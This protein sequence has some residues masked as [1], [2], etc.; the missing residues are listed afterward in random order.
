MSIK[1]KLI[2][3]VATEMHSSYCEDE[4]RDFFTRMKKI[5]S[6]SF[7]KEESK[8]L[9]AA[10]F[11]NG[12]RR[13]DIILDTEWLQFNSLKAI[14][15]F[16][17]YKVFKELFNNGIIEIKDFVPRSLTEI[18]IREKQ[19]KGDYKTETGEE[20]ILRPFIV[21]SQASKKENIDG[22]LGAYQVYE[23]L[24]MAGVT[25]EQMEKDYKIR[26]LI[27]IAI[28][29]D[30]LQRNMNHENDNLKIPYNFLEKQGQEQDLTVF[31]ALLKVVKVNGDKY[32]ISPVQNH[33]IKDYIALEQEV[34]SSKNE[35]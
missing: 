4:L 1:E 28:H 2:I 7:F 30:W 19:E 22:A 21:L 16:T 14:Q 12:K 3:E 9:E 26:N 8:I 25:I 20:N 10:C 29:T 13:N 35:I 27:G 23:D 18:E 5:K 11:V 17:D 33:Q 6:E 24:A 15:M 32:M 31:D 34:L